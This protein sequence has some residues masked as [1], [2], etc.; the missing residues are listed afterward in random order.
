[1]KVTRR[2]FLTISGAAAVAGSAL[3]K[4][5][6]PPPEPVVDPPVDVPPDV[7]PVDLRIKYAQEVFT[8]CCFCSSGCGSTCWVEDG[9]VISID[10]YPDSPLNEG[11]N[12]S[13]GASLFNFRNVY[14]PETGEL[15][16]NPNRVTK[17]LYRAP[18]ASDWEERDWDWALGEIAKRVKE[19]RDATFEHTDANGVTVNRTLAIGHLGSAAINNEEN[20]L[21]VK[22]MRA[23]GVLNIDHHARL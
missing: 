19:T 22:L 12:C 3:F 10:G 20:Y 16:L 1:M 6:C 11:A 17:V 13:K 4:L 23:M 9:E 18:G 21:M 14:D 8:V 2:K 15:V 5:G 7:E